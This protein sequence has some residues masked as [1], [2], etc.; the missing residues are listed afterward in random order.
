MRQRL[1][2]GHFREEQNKEGGGNPPANSS[3]GPGPCHLW[4][5]HQTN[6]DNGNVVW[7][8]HRHHACAVHHQIKG[9]N[10]EHHHHRR[11]KARQGKA[12]QGK[13]GR[14]PVSRTGEGDT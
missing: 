11:G 10:R 5:D 6:G 7:S 2:L 8:P 4:L 9:P 3:P 13:A 12:R 1:D 14:G